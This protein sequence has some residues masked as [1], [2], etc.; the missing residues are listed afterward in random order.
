MTGGR[1]QLGFDGEDLMPQASLFCI[2]FNFEFC[3]NNRTCMEV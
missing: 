1:K 3:F 2:P